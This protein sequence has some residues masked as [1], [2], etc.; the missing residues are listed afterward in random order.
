MNPAIERIQ[1]QRI[2]IPDDQRKAL[3]EEYLWGLSIRATNALVTFG[4]AS[5]EDVLLLANAGYL[6][7]IRNVGKKTRREIEERLGEKLSKTPTRP[8][9]EA[10]LED[11]KDAWS[12]NKHQQH[13]HSWH[14]K[15]DF[16]EKWT[17]AIA[18]ARQ[19]A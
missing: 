12:F 11:L 2:T 7:R 8:T 1:N 5:R 6:S 18:R 16:I 14:D 3:I 9:P 4:A 13:T 17:A 10:I 19:S 15:Q